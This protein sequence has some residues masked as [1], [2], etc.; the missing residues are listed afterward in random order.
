M[1][2]IRR[3]T[4]KDTRKRFSVC[5]MCFYIRLRSCIERDIFPI[6]FWWW[7][8]RLCTSPSFSMLWSWW[9]LIVGRFCLAICYGS[10][11]SNWHFTRTHLV[12]GQSATVSAQML[13]NGTQTSHT[14]MVKLSRTKVIPG[15]PW[16]SVITESLGNTRLSFCTCCL[17]TQ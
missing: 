10:G 5:N 16:E 4:V 7:L 12:T 11:Q 17:R 9:R 8:R 3:D 13:K 15:R 1:D 2:Q 6:S 14:T